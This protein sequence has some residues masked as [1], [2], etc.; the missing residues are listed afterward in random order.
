MNDVGIIVQGGLYNNLICSLEEM[1][2]SGYNLMHT[3]HTNKN[4]VKDLMQ[5]I[6]SAAQWVI[7]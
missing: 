7:Q 5:I 6:K 4:K 1:S 3:N 2:L